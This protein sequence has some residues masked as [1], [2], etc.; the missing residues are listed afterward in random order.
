M[1]L[2]QNDVICFLKQNEVM[3]KLSRV[4][5]VAKNKEEDYNV[6]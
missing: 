4:W 1:F 2:K 6:L 5:F 3:H